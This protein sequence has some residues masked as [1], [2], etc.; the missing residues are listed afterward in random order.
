MPEVNVNLSDLKAALVESNATFFSQGQSRL[1]R[2]FVSR[3][4][5][6]QTILTRRPMLPALHRGHRQRHNGFRHRI[7]MLLGRRPSLPS[8]RVPMAPLHPSFRFQP[9]RHLYLPSKTTL[10]ILALII[11]HLFAKQVDT[12]KVECH[13]Q[14]CPRLDCPSEQQVRPDSLACC[15]VRNMTILSPLKI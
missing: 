9:L 4:E 2:Y 13:S 11:F 3:S 5:L 12:L 7:R 6:C 1:R 8:C 10:N 15:Q 14:K